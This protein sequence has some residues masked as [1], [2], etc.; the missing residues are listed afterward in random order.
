LVCFFGADPIRR[1]QVDKA[2]RE[3]LVRELIAFLAEG[4]ALFRPGA[5]FHQPYSGC[6]RQLGGRLVLYTQHATPPHSDVLTMPGNPIV[7]FTEQPRPEGHS[8]AWHRRC[9]VCC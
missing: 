6:A 3:E 2:F 8:L 1:K 4:P 9:I 7:R 5:K